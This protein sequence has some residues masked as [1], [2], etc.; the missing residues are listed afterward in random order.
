MFGKLMSIPDHLIAKYELLA[1]R[2]GPD[3][4]RAGR[5][6]ARRRVDPPQRREARDGARRSSTCTTAPARCDGR[7]PRSTGCSSEHDVPEDAPGG[8][9]AGRRRP[10]GHD[11]A[12]TASLVA[13][14]L[15]GSNAEAKRRV[16][17]GGVRLDGDGRST[18]RTRSCRLDAADRGDTLQVGRRAV[19]ARLTGRRTARL[20]LTGSAPSLLPSLRRRGTP[21]RGP[22]TA[23]TAGIRASVRTLRT[24][25]RVNASAS[26]GRG[27]VRRVRAMTTVQIQE[28]PASRGG[29]GT[30]RTER[31]LFAPADSTETAD[32]GPSGRRGANLYG[33]FDPGS[34]RTLAARL[35]HAS[36]TVNGASAPGSVANGC[37]TRGQP[38]PHSGI[39]PGNRS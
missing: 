1:H 30:G 35:T 13:A 23:S 32:P 19:R 24:E 11:L 25:Q 14:G 21:A 6:R 15:A 38:A 22:Y 36:R 33:E 29:S 37:V 28:P 18:I 5:R 4:A 27:A 31:C 7:R 16:A 12:P 9:P 20:G 39:T 10:R 26:S 2:P 3:D 8:P 17:Q 34:G